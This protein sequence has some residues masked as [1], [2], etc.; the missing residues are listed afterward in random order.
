MIDDASA[1]GDVSLLGPFRKRFRANLD[2]SLPMVFV[3]GGLAMLIPFGCYLIIRKAGP[4]DAVRIGCL[5]FLAGLAAICLYGVRFYWRASRR[6]VS[7]HE[8]GVSYF[9]G[10]RGHAIPWSE[11]AEIYEVTSGMT[12]LGISVGKSKPEVTIVT[13]Q[14]VQVR[15]DK[16]ILGGDELAPMV[17]SAV[18]DLLRPH[19]EKR[20]R[21][22]EPVTF[23]CLSVSEKGIVIEKPSRRSIVGSVQYQ[24][25]TDMDDFEARPGDY[26]WGDIRDIRIATGSSH[27]AS[28]KQVEI[29]VVGHKFP[30][31][32]CGIP[33][34]PNF[35]LFTETLRQLNRPLK[36]EVE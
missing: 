25:E 36:G 1:K 28:Y 18:N 10:T 24:L 16:T 9:D 17:A 32:L 30:A 29:Y 5:L 31:F 26:A 6:A 33:E 3:L 21:N 34:F 14:G 11:I 23:G 12:V 20:L 19:A 4:W 27:T 13:D 35:W 7:L 22:R 8:N 15:I 2:E